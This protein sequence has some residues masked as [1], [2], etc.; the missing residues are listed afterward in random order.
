LGTNAYWLGT[1]V[2]DD[3][4]TKTLKNVK[5]QGIKVVRTW[6]FNGER[7]L[8]PCH[9]AN[10]CSTLFLY[11]TL[12]SLVIRTPKD[13]TEIPSDGTVYFQLIKDGHQTINDGPNGLQKLDKIV[14]VAEELG[15]FVQISLTNN[16][17]PIKDEKPHKGKDGLKKRHNDARPRNALSND[18]GERLLNFVAAYGMYGNFFN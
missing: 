3:D 2:N 4:I 11:L 10:T 14:K 1:L 18:Y 8:C 16:W 17:N 9:D 6:G 13:V 5:S 15:L 12:S 7:P